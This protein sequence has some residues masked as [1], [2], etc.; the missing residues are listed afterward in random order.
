M[1]TQLYKDLINEKE[2]FDYINKKKDRMINTC[3]Y[4]SLEKLYKSF[5]HSYPKTISNIQIQSLVH[6]IMKNKN[7]YYLSNL[8]VLLCNFISFEDSL[9][10]IDELKS[11][12]KITDSDIIKFI[13]ARRKSYFKKDAIFA[14]VT[15][16]YPEI[17][18]FQHMTN[19]IKKYIKRIKNPVYL[20]LCCGD[21]RKTMLIS[22]M[23][24][25]ENINGTDI[26]M[27]GPYKKNRVMPFNFKFIEDNGNLDYPDN[28]FDI[29]TCILSLH[30]IRDLA[31][32]LN[33]IK[34]IL[35]PNG[36]F[37]IIE[38]D[39]YTHYDSMIIE[40][41]HTL[42]AILYDNNKD[43][44]KNPLFSRYLNNM[45]WE[46]IFTKYGFIFLEYG[47]YINNIAESKRYDQQFFAIYKNNKNYKK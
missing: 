32:T 23:L 31:N 43:Y 24:K 11:D 41:Q 22:K 15:K 13:E 12:K 28:S 8:T 27:W 5:H 16:C 45:E 39:N 35:K 20:D 46:F 38:H 40:I 37:I 33:E 4:D 36:I 26:K 7:I 47:T 44:I 9:K 21:G 6:D 2:Y 14:P 3:K 19:I 30:H 10:L 1:N 25:I 34:R 17:Y 18:G 42:F 29:I